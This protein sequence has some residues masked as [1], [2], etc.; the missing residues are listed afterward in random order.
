MGEELDMAGQLLT[1]FGCGVLP[2]IE[3]LSCK[4]RESHNYYGHAI[5]YREEYTQDLRT[6]RHLGCNASST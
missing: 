4:E 5:C 3:E 2:N 1:S 6:L